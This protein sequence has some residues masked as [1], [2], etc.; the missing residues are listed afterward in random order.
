[1]LSRVKEL[2]KLPQLEELKKLETYSKQK[3]I[4]GSL[5]RRGVNID[6]H[7]CKQSIPLPNGVY[8]G[9]WKETVSESLCKSCPYFDRE[10]L[11]YKLFRRT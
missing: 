5:K 10:P 1:M 6:Y 4:R 2:K 11:E 7:E 3:K 8:C 9:L